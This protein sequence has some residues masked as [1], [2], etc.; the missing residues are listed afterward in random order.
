[1]NRMVSRMVTGIE[2]EQECD[3]IGLALRTPVVK[4]Q[5]KPQIIEC[6]KEL[7]TGESGSMYREQPHLPEEPRK[8]MGHEGLIG[9]YRLTQSQE[10]LR[11]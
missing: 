5:I 7:V 4:V 3:K 9:G 11:K 1:M 10:V 2:N 6:Q 8:P